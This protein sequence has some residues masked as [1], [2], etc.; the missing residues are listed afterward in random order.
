V[1]RGALARASAFGALLL[2]SGLGCKGGGGNDVAPCDSIVFT[3]AVGSPTAG[4]V[5]LFSTG[6]SCDMI[7]V[8]VLVTDL[9]GIFT[10]GFTIDYPSTLIAYQGFSAGTLLAQGSPPTAPQYFVTTPSAGVLVVSG[11][12]FRPD[13][14]VSAT[15]S[16]IFITLHF[17]RVA[18]GTGTVDFD[19]GG[20]ITNQI[21][22]ENGTVVAA[23]FGPGHG[24]AIQVP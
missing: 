15:G 7:D 14:S 11:T 10:V 22:D 4:D 3:P 23:S 2:I 20:S 9:S 5:F 16:A 12:L 13:A 18:G 8:S 19:M 21:I 1:S 17:L 24:G 6:S